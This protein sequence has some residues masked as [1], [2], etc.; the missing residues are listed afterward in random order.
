MK[1]LAK[2]IWSAVLAV[3]VVGLPATH[4]TGADKK[5]EI[6]VGSELDYPPYALVTADGRADGFSVDLMKAVCEVM[7]IKVSFRVGPWNEVFRALGRGEIDA[8]PLVSY[9]E[10][11]EKIF[12][13]TAPH[14]IGNGVLFKRT[15]SPGIVA[16]EEMR[17]TSTLV[18]KNDATHEW[19]VRNGLSDNLVLTPT[20]P[21]ALRVLASGEHDYAF[22]PRL[23]GLLIANESRLDN[24]EVTGPVVNVHGRGYGFAVKE[25]NSDLLDRF[26]EGLRIIKATGRYD[27]IYD[28][29]FAIVAPRGVP[30]AVVTR[31]VSLA[32]AGVT[33]L[34]FL[35]LAWIVI[36]RRTVAKQTASLRL[37]QDNLELRIEERTAELRKSEARLVNAQRIAHLGNWDW[38]V[39]TGSLRWSDEIYR[40]FG[41]ESNNDGLTYEAFLELIHPDDRQAVVTAVEKALR[42][43]SSY[44]MDYR[45]IWPDGSIRHVHT[46]GEVVFDKAGEPLS[47]SGTVYDITAGKK[48]E[49]KI[50]ASLKE[51]EVLLQEIHHRVKNNL[52]VISGMLW[53]QANTE[54]DVHTKEVI[55]ESYRRVM[56]MAHVY[57]SLHLQG[58]LNVINAREFLNTL[59]ADTK[60]SGGGILE[61]ISF[62]V[63]VDDI[64]LD[65]DHANAY[66]QII[67]ELISNCQKHAFVNASS[68]NVDVSLR[69]KDGGAIEL[70]VAD[71]GKGLPKDFNLHQ[72]KTLGLQLVC[73][74]AASMGGDV[75]FDGSAGTCFEIRFCEEHPS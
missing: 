16:M 24:L 57:A 42:N 37:A 30:S 74:L 9:S 70:I 66:G 58:D 14:T 65:V 2:I 36:L 39:K 21:E 5:T 59:V 48:A 15:E 27:E 35:V 34:I 63:D 52:Q 40:L 56:L 73:A 7:G 53:L 19:L 41:R 25:G 60:A 13:F 28:K 71:D 64:P 18:M 47:M 4:A 23:V 55:Q 45:I 3:V 22:V 10:Q 31:Y 51:K 54:N 75:R 43:E 62:H 8:L 11:R 1:C 12:D 69:Q 38:N 67:S 44:V 29:W 61:Q 33:V 20:V 46:Q 50:K 32:A 26:N 17:D 49:E 6:I 68:G 72:T